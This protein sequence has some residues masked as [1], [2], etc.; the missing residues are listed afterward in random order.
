MH[1]AYKTKDNFYS[2]KGLKTY[3]FY[4]K[5]IYWNFTV[6]KIQQKL[7]ESAK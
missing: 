2:R 3:Q 4:T 1:V 5:I 7:Q 6:L